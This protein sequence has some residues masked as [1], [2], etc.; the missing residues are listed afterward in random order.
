MMESLSHVGPVL[1]AILGFGALI[2]L[3]ELGHFLAA[4]W[5]GVRVLQFA[6]GFGPALLSYRKG[7]GLRWGS[8][9]PEYRKLLEARGEGGEPGRLETR[10]VAGVSPTE[11][12]LNWLPF[13]GY[14]K[15]LG[16]EDL[17]PAA[18]A[19]TPDSYT[20]QPIWKRMVIISGGIVMNLLVAAGL[21]VAVFMAGLPAMAP[22]VGAATR[23]PSQAD[24]ASDTQEGQSDSSPPRELPGLSQRN[25]AN[26]LRPGDRILRVNGRKIRSFNDVV[27]SVAM[28]PAGKPVQLLVQRPGV[29]HPLK[30]AIEPWRNPATGM[31]DIGAAPALDAALI[32]PA[33]AAS[34]ALF[35]QA[36]ERA[37]LADVPP[38]ARFVEIN[39][40]A[41]QGAWDIFDAVQTSSGDP[42]TVVLIDPRTGQ[43]LERR[44]Q[45]EP[46]L[47]RAMARVDEK[48]DAVVVEHLLGLTPAPRVAVALERAKAFGLQAGDV[49]AQVE[50]IAWPDRATL[51]QRIRANAGREI[52]LS[53]ERDGELVDL[54]ARVRSDGSIGFF[55]DDDRWLRARTTLPPPGAPK[56][57]TITDSHGR[58]LP[59]QRLQLPPGSIVLRVAGQP[60]A[61]YRQ[62]RA[63]LRDATAEAHEQGE[64]A[65]VE[66]T[67]KLPV[68]GSD[69]QAEA[70]FE[71]TAEEVRRLHSLGWRSPLAQG[72]F[73]PLTTLLKASSP[74][75]AIVMGAAETRRIVLMTY[76]TL[77]RL[78]QGSVEV[79]SLKGPVG[80]AD[81]GAK[82]ARTGPIQLLFFLAVISAN[83]AVVNFLPLPIV[84]GGLF[85]MLLYEWIRGRPVP[86]AAQN[87]LTLIGLALIVSLFLVVTFNDVM[88]ILR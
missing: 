39:G 45:P 17:D 43:R 68:A 40:H 54:I 83:L 11:Y 23:P 60:V 41:V 6:L 8:T 85:L 42:L 19:S 61:D 32:T 57:A 4:R 73:E 81:I 52:A 66:L 38:G 2:F 56:R 77:L 14:V 10:T 15:M 34:D 75:E 20:Q 18:T 64:G 31:L 82:V 87:A 65:S 63:A 9:T 22:V 86:V 37:G 27:V 72:L 3:H 79:Q 21:F 70:T 12:R 46:A 25:A 5:A 50:D 78:V 26:P 88:A 47:E 67:V 69:A 30:L 44:L 84:D 58:P 74:V 80:I 55:L 53:V 48:H 33:D 71:L 16:Q 51:L 36:L 29:D 28:A 76:L 7:L 24:D 1:V 62:L 59:A 35:Q 49:L 13:G